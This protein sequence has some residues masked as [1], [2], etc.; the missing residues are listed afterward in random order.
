MM[1]ERN[2]SI[3]FWL[4]VS[5]FVRER[6]SA[7]FFFYLFFLP[8]YSSSCFLSWGDYSVKNCERREESRRI[9]VRMKGMGSFYTE[10]D[11]QDQLLFISS[12]GW[13]SAWGARKIKGWDLYLGSTFRS[14]AEN[15]P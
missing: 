15:H 10:L 3:F 5:F 14:M 2:G 4:L 9:C 12:N 8:F 1:K 13:N 7:L 11:G 6:E